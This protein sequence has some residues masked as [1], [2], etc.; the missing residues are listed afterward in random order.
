MR[1]PWQPEVRE[2]SGSSE[3]VR[4]LL[5]GLVLFGIVGLVLELLLLEHTESLTQAMPLAVLGGG[6]ACGVAVA[7]RPTHTTVRLFQ[8]AMTLFV[9]T[10]VLGLVLHLRGNAAFEREMD[11]SM[12][13]LALLW[14]SLRGATPALAPGALVQVGLLGLIQTYR[15]PALSR[16][17]A[18]GVAVVR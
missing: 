2:S 1:M 6:L 10:G 7:L 13:G 15:H 5:L 14:R 17:S 16:P 3:A 4:R 9:L 18:T 11:A 12:Q 8:A